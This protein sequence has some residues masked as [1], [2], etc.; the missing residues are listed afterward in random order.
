[1][2]E[3][4]IAELTEKF[5]YNYC[6]YPGTCSNQDELDQVCDECPMNRVVEMLD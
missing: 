5:C 1:M 2:V 3:D 4:K 6:K